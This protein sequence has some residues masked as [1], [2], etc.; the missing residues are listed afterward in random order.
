VKNVSHGDISLFCLG[1][2]AGTIHIPY[3]NQG[4]FFGELELHIWILAR[5]QRRPFLIFFP[6]RKFS[7]LNFRLAC[8]P[9]CELAAQIEF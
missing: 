6:L 5:D 8:F 4:E 2:Q 1:D 3:G 7:S 9:N